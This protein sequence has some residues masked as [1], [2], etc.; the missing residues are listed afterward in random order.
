MAPLYKNRSALTGLAL[1]AVFAFPAFSQSAS[2]AGGGVQATSKASP[3]DKQVAE[4]VY[5]RLKADDVD[6][7]KHVTVSAE[8][9]VVT[10]GG[11]VATTEALNKA[12]KIAQG[13]PGVTQVSDK[14]TLERAPNQ[15]P[16]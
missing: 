5:E 3:G 9:G 11:T 12:K 16:Q 15:P 8:N 10:L 4:Q 1:A 2:D 14:M 7:Y 6:Y 13:V